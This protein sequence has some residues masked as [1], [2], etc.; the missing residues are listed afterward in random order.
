MCNLIFSHPDGEVGGEKMTLRCM[1]CQV[2]T[3]RVKAWCLRSEVWWQ[4][5][6]PGNVTPP[7]FRRSEA[8]KVGKKTRT[9][10]GI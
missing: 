1:L 5:A 7:L 2:G 6:C 3:E 9:I 8:G 10:K 4:A